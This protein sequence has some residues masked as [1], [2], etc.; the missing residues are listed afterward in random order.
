MNK[1]YIYGL[2]A[3]ALSVTT[4]C[5]NDEDTTPSYADVNGFMPSDDDH[6]EVAV[7]RREFKNETGCYLLFNDTLSKQQTGTDSYGN[8]YYYV[9]YVD[10]NYSMVSSYSDYANSYKYITDP[11]AMREAAQ[12]VKSKLVNRLGNSLPFSFL[13]VDTIYNWTTDEYNNRILSSKTPYLTYKLGSNCCVVSMNGGLAND[14]DVYFKSM[15][16]DIVYSKLKGSSDEDMTEFFAPVN[17]Y[18]LKYKDDLGYQRVYNDSIARTLG[19]YE[20]WNRYYFCTKKENDLKNYLTAVFTMTDEE[21]NEEFSDFPICQAR[22]QK[23]KDIL[24]NMGV[25]ID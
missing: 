21:F 2:V 20:D 8:P 6:S 4:A 3:L 23:L 18:I 11:V 14:D 12:A 9:K 13:L 7:L 16:C 10:V 22:F 15:V 1:K 24:K 19:F 17:A 25:K 5:S